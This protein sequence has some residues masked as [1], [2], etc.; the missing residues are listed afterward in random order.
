MRALEAVRAVRLVRRH[1]R[2]Q[3]V[4]RGFALLE[5]RAR[6]ATPPD[7]GVF[8]VTRTVKVNEENRD[9]ER[10]IR[11]R[12]RRRGLTD[13]RVRSRVSARGRFGSSSTRARRVVVVAVACVDTLVSCLES[14]RPR[15]EPRSRG[16]R[17][18]PSRGPTPESRKLRARGDVR[19]LRARVSE[20]DAHDSPRLLKRL[21]ACATHAA[22][23]ARA[24]SRS[25]AGPCVRNTFGHHEKRSRGTFP[26]S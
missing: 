19:V 8:R 25:R 2:Q 1:R 22:G 20:L 15:H 12:V 9:G 24:Y 14:L 18:N 26:F 7:A 11:D 17:P 21:H 4:R 3:T 16:E 23:A 10:L 6:V 5:R 13:A